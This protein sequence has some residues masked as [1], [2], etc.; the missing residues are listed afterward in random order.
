MTGLTS[1]S[2]RWRLWAERLWPCRAMLHQCDWFRQHVLIMRLL[3]GPL[4]HII[5][6]TSGSQKAVTRWA[7]WI[8]LTRLVKAP[9]HSEQLRMHSS[10]STKT[11]CESGLVHRHIFP[12]KLLELQ[13]SG[14]NC[15]STLRS[16]REEDEVRR[17]RRA[18][19]NPSVMFF[20]VCCKKNVRG[21]WRS[22]WRC[23]L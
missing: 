1:W 12:R 16:K 7:L 10:G 3:N 17:K 22:W 19:H 21:C 11:C 9:R 6:S 20:S 2:Q 5:S 4:S 14:W 13:M 15:E 23:L 8:S 18:I